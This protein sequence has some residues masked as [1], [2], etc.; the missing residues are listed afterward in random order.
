[1]NLLANFAAISAFAFDIDGVMTDNTIQV[2][3][4]GELLRTMHIRD[5][6]A[7][8]W[9]I[10]QGYPIA[11]ITGGSS[12]GVIAR[13]QKLGIQA[14]FSG[15]TDKLTVLQTWCTEQQINPDEVLYMGDDIPD[16]AP[17][18]AVGL[19]TCP[20]DAC[21]ETLQLA[22]YVSPIAGGKGCVR[23][24]IEKVLKLQGKWT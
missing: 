10:K 23:D 21:S 18:Q 20:A 12:Q 15:V 5:G 3:E 11:I 8:Q 17:M 16:I 2:T 14:I 19:P 7:L 13:L 6:Y 22:K 1:M 9:A 24:V 4:T